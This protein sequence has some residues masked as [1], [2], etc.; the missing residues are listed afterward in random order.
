MSPAGRPPVQKT[1]I[2]FGEMVYW[3]TILAAIVCMVGP[4]IAMINPDNNVANPHYL[5]SAIFAGKDAATI[6]KEAGGSFPG[7]HFY[8]HNITKGDGFTQL[9][10]ALGCSSAFY[11]LIAVAF[12]YG[13]RK[14]YLY[15]ALSLWVAILILGSLIGI[16]SGH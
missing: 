9:G 4:V 10:L 1:Q 3:V 2:V 16:V 13:R 14:N 7:G 6:W 5:F 8:L 15:M 12:I 11:A